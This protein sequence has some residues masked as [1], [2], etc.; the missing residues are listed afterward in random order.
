MPK[1][2]TQNATAIKKYSVDSSIGKIPVVDVTPQIL[3]SHIPIIIAPGWS[4]ASSNYADT[5]SVLGNLGR[6]SIAFDHPRLGGEVPANAQY[7]KAELRKATALIDVINFLNGQVDVIAHSEGTLYTIIAATLHPEIFKN[8]VL[9]APAGLIGP[10]NVPALARRFLKKE[11]RYIAQGFKDK[12]SKNQSNIARQIIQVH[13]RSG[14]YIA[15][16]PKRAFDEGVAMS[17]ADT[18]HML[19]VLRQKGIGIVVIHHADDEAFPMPRIQKNVKA[20]LFDG[21]LAVTGLHDDLITHP[22][23][24]VVAAE[25]MLKA[26]ENKRLRTTP[27]IA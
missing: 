21:I 20:K 24:Y 3:S 8:I 1:T 15:T 10:D 6:R 11:K 19:E 7:P 25:E 27:T 2:E 26:L 22:E 13:L 23:K 9:M 5:Q 14:K 12:D 18:T 4:E 16:N 17:Q